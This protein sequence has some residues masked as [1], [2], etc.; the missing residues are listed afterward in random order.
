LSKDVTIPDDDIER[1]RVIADVEARLFGGE[2]APVKVGRFE[3]KR[4]IGVGGLGVVYAAF[5]PELRRDVALKLLRS[6]RGGDGRESTGMLAEARAMARLAHPNV[7]TVHEVGVHEGRVFVAMELVDG[8]TLREWLRRDSPRA[9]QEVL[10]VLVAAGRGLAAAHG[11]GLVHRDFKPEN[12]LVGRDGRARVTDF[13]LARASASESPSAS[14]NG[15]DAATRTAIAGTPA[16][17]APEQHDGLPCTPAA[18]QFAFAVTAFEALYGERPFAGESVAALAEAKRAGRATRAP[19]GDVP[20]RI[21]A[22]IARGFA[23]RPA[24]RFASID[25]MLDALEKRPRAK[26]VTIV[27]AVVAIAL[28]IAVVAAAMQMWMFGHWMKGMSR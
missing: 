23:T 22:T 28:G 9:W 10:P 1:R 27:I 3:I 8:Q 2:A 14:A 4:R 18:D 17:M 16:Y 5:D 7:V 19:A 21:E 11:A 12:V 24:D 6:D 25:A 26:G 13:G 15:E 20:Q